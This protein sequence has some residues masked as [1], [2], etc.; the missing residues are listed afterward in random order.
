MS[1]IPRPS[2]LAAS[3]QGDWVFHGADSRFA[4]MPLRYLDAYTMEVASGVNLEAALQD[5]PHRGIGPTTVFRPFPST[6]SALPMLYGNVVN[7]EDY[8]SQ[9]PK[10]RQQAALC[11]HVV[12]IISDF[13]YGEEA[14]WAITKDNQAF[15]L[16]TASNSFGHKIFRPREDFKEAFGACI[17]RDFDICIQALYVD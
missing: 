13:T 4:K 17:L 8:F 1:S 2:S 6:D 16:A 11:G 3:L 14:V 12:G 15:V 10:R 5:L 9:R 7:A